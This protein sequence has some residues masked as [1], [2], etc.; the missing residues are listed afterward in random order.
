[1]VY[2]KKEPIGH[3]VGLDIFFLLEYSTSTVW[4][5]LRAGSID[6]SGPF[7][8]TPETRF[9]LQRGTSYDGTTSLDTEALKKY[10]INKFNEPEN[11]QLK[12]LLETWDGWDTFEKVISDW[13]CVCFVMDS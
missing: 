7:T 6:C 13:Y 10:M 3:L 4:L 8:W 12:E 11:N 9:D 5:E 1:V 2:K